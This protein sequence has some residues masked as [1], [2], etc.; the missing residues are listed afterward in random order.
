[1]TIAVSFVDQ[2]NVPG[3]R[4]QSGVYIDIAAPG[5]SILSTALGDYGFSTG[6]SM[7]AAYVSGAAALLFAAQPSLTATQARDILLQSATDIAAPGRDDLT[8]NGLLNVANAFNVLA[9]LFPDSTQP[10]VAS[11]GRVNETLNAVVNPNSSVQWY[12]CTKQGPAVARKPANCT[13]IPNAVVPRYRTNT[14]DVGK[15][16]RVAARVPG[17]KSMRFSA[18]TPRIMAKWLRTNQVVASSVT[19]FT[20]LLG[21]PSRGSITARVTTGSCVVKRSTLV[22]PAG[23]DT[24][25]IA[26]RVAARSPFPTMNLTIQVIVVQPTVAP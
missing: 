22:A 13:A 19:P 10:A 9:A 20:A 25:T 7:A 1:L 16:L 14:R 15:F 24:C 12:R 11:L 17:E 21:G 23:P 4:S 3:A 5:V 8:G 6:S 2:Q 18:T 26:V